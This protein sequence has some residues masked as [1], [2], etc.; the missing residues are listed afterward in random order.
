[1][2]TLTP[3]KD[4][5]ATT[6]PV[7]VLYVE[8]ERRVTDSMLAEQI[9][10]LG[11]DTALLADVLSAVLTHERC[12]RHLYRSCARRTARAELRERFEEFGRETERH[13]EILEGLIRQ[14]GGNPNYVSPNARAVEGTDSNL[15]ESTFLLAGSI[16]AV[17]AE[18][19]LVDAVFIA[20]SVDHANWKLMAKLTQ[21]LPDGPIREA[22]QAAVDEVEQQEDE[23]LAWATNTKERLILGLVT[24]PDT[25][26]GDIADAKDELT[27]QELYAEAQ[28]RDVP[29]RSSMTKDQLVDALEEDEAN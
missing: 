29:G 2:P 13:V 22:F 28:A 21:Q 5:G 23:H 27:K 14:S 20:E 6:K 15:L 24:G 11:V 9:G 1:M 18:L 8:P 26:A 3:T 10:D 25:P 17:T 12:G 16:D 7:G 4:E 19:A